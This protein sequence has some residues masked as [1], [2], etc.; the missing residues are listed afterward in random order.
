MLAYGKLTR[1]D[2]FAETVPIGGPESDQ[3]CKF[4][5]LPRVHQSVLPTSD[6]TARESEILLAWL[7]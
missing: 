5:L 3:C 7:I 1:P 6:V 4:P 2:V